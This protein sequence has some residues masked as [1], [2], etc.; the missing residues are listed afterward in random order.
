MNFEHY[1]DVCSDI[2]RTTEKILKDIESLDKLANNQELNLMSSKTRDFFSGEFQE[3]LYDDREKLLSD[4]ST[5]S[6]K[7][8]AI[9]TEDDKNIIQHCKDFHKSFS[10]IASSEIQNM[11]QIIL[12]WRGNLLTAKNNV[13]K[14]S[15]RLKEFYEN[16]PRND[17]GKQQCLILS[18]QIVEKYNKFTRDELVFRMDRLL[19]RETE[20]MNIIEGM[21]MILRT[22]KG[23][24]DESLKSQEVLEKKVEYLENIVRESNEKIKKLEGEN[25]EYRKK[26]EMRNKSIANIK[27]NSQESLC[28]ESMKW[29]NRIISGEI[30]EYYNSPAKV[31]KLVAASINAN[32]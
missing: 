10:D 27:I 28:T 12:K 21:E 6:K 23:E 29:S 20:F 5:W 8:A 31:C 25:S 16:A 24:L 22:T 18:D 2:N 4:L 11:L 30:T 15:T 32:P 14:L 26:E 3:L 7:R 9:F 17:D 19:T 13:T 1:Y